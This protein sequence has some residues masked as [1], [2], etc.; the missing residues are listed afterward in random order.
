[1]VRFIMNNFVDFPKLYDH[2]HLQNGLAYIAMEKLNASVYDA[3]KTK[4][5]SIEQAME[6]ARQTVKD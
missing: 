6:L 4:H 5:M 1:M 2:G 3:T